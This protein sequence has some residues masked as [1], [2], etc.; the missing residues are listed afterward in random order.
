MPV[1]WTFS[2]VQYSRVMQEKCPL[3]SIVSAGQ[4]HFILIIQEYCTVGTVTVYS[5]QKQCTVVTVTVYSIQ[6][7]CTVGTVTVYSMQKQCTVV[8]VAVYSIQ[9]IV[10]KVLAPLLLP[11]QC[12]KLY[13]FR[14]K[15]K[16]L[17][18]RTIFRTF[19]LGPERLV[20]KIAQKRPFHCTILGKIFWRYFFIFYQDNSELTYSSCM[21]TWDCI[22]GPYHQ[23][24]GPDLIEK[25]SPSARRANRI[26]QRQARL[27]SVGFVWNT[28]QQALLHYTVYRNSVQCALL[29]CTVYR[30]IV[31][32]ALVKYAVYSFQEYCKVGTI[33]L[34]SIQEYYTVGTGKV[35]IIQ[36]YCAVGTFTV[37]LQEYCTMGIHY[38]GTVYKKNCL[39]FTIHYQLVFCPENCSKET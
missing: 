16:C 12:F 21:T 36:E 22:I 25:H 1:Y 15:E 34:Y 29:Q 28:V 13:F 2:T 8:T 35:K 23:V 9:N 24:C 32:W 14:C 5:I 33:T 20:Q 3:I 6:E 39:G 27:H 17:I 30:N 18:K 11:K 37:T 38:T 31:Q 19:L 26:R 4:E 7:Y 10:I